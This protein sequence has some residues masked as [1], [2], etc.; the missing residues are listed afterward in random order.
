[1]ALGVVTQIQTPYVTISRTTALKTDFAV[2]TKKKKKKKNFIVHTPTHGAILR[3]ESIIDKVSLKLHKASSKT[4]CLD[5]VNF[6]FYSTSDENA[7]SP[8]SHRPVIIVK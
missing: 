1:M 6:F 7:N 2:I 5:T 3:Y 4:F 8:Y